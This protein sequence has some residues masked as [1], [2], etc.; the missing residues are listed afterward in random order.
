MPSIIHSAQYERV[1]LISLVPSFHFY[2]FYFRCAN[3]VGWIRIISYKVMSTYHVKGNTI[4][5]HTHTCMPLSVGQWWWLKRNQHIRR[6]SLR[7]ASCFY[8]YF[9][10]IFRRFR[11]RSWGGTSEHIACVRAVVKPF[12]SDILIFH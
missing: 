12:T 11:L 9:S 6:S 5:T 3:N 2:R 8:C 7:G 4:Y 10:S 1:E